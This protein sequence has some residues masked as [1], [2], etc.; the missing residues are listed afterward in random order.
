MRLVCGTSNVVVDDMHIDFRVLDISYSGT[1]S[2]NTALGNNWIIIGSQNRII[3]ANTGSPI[4]TNSI[5]LF[6]YSG[7]F[8]VLS[9]RAALPNGEFKTLKIKTVGVDYWSRLNGNWDEIESKFDDIGSSRNLKGT[10]FKPRVLNK[11]TLIH[12]KLTA[13]EGEW[14]YEN[15]DPYL[16]TDY[17]VHLDGQ[18]MTG[19]V[20]SKDSRN[21]YRKD[22]IGTIFKIKN[23]FRKLALSKQKA[24]RRRMNRIKFKENY[25]N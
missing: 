10:D 22:A 1:M 4:N 13:L 9:C 25:G 21:I 2:A 17:H 24:V 15:G 20:F 14:F 3:F 5:Q 6:T 18:A 19:R 8:R 11:S 7:S 23:E 16:E 12:T